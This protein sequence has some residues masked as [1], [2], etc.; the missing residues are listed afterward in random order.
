MFTDR[1][2]PGKG[3]SLQPQGIWTRSS[4]VQQKT[5]NYLIEKYFVDCDQSVTRNQNLLHRPRLGRIARSPSTVF[6][7]GSVDNEPLPG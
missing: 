1:A 2:K 6:S 7:T 3:V 5:L 4:K